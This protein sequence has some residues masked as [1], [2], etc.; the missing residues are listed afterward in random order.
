MV[1]DAA[2]LLHAGE[3]LGSI[4]A[5]SR[6]LALRGQPIELGRKSL[7]PWLGTIWK[8]QD[9]FMEH[10]QKVMDAQEKDMLLKTVSST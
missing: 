1:L 10:A 3:P 9:T 6:V 8:R 7:Q 2:T 5:V 4:L